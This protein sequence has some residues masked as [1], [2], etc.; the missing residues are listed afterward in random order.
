VHFGIGMFVRRITSITAALLCMSSVA[1]LQR[2][3]ASVETVGHVV[4]PE[5][6]SPAQAQAFKVPAGFS[7][8]VFAEGL[9]KPRMLEVAADGSVYRVAYGSRPTTSARPAAK[10]PGTAVG[11]SGAREERGGVI[12]MERPETRAEAASSVTSPA[13]Q[14]R[15][16]IPDEILRVADG[17]SRRDHAE[18]IRALVALQR[19]GCD[20]AAPGIRPDA[21]ST[22][23]A[24]RRPS[25]TELA[26][27]DRVCRPAATRRR[28]SASLPLSNLCARHAVERTTR[29]RSRSRS[30][31]DGRAC[32]RTRR[33]GWHVPAREMTRGRRVYQE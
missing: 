1:A 20:H 16:A 8:S 17:G 11:T 25:G 14:P 19:A 33:A 15:A 5:Q 22:Q 23:R 30:E 3:S 9:G 7:V 24:R 4:K 29:R 28:S 10:P 26:R 6:L 12:A 2:R 31:S 18:A 32:H 27:S 21:T 13:F